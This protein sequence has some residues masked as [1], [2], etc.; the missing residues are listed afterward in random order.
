MEKEYK[1]NW[2]ETRKRFLKWWKRQEMDRPL[3][4]VRAPKF[5]NLDFFPRELNTEVS[6]YQEVSKGNLVNIKKKWLDIFGIVD[7]T[8]KMFEQTAYLGGAF[9]YIIPY[10]GAGSFGTFLGATPAFCPGTVWYKPC[11]QDIDK[12]QLSLNHDSRWWKWSINFSKI[13]ANRASGKY[14][15]SIPD[16]IENLDTLAAL[17]GTDKLLYYLADT[18]GEIHRLQRQLLPLW[19]EAFE[20]HYQIVKDFEGWNAFPTS[21]WGPGK[22]AKLQCDFSSMISPAMFNEFVLPYLKE[23][24]DRLDYTVYHLDGPGALCHLDALLTI[25]SLDCINWVPGAGQPDSGDS[26]WDKI[27]RKILDVG[28]GIQAFMD[29]SYVKDFVKRFGT[30]G[31][32]IVTTS[33]TV[34]EGKEL[35]RDSHL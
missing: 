32:F 31:V 18:P 8:E 5:R 26:C 11:F 17:L 13:A 34:E 22:T 14:L 3:L 24:S 21:V 10:L 1:E 4:L 28:K 20:E 16:L 25:D 33:T 9:P 35:I 7:Q 30:K 6:A 2:E 23:Q 27:Y 12:V 19:F 15:V 29:A